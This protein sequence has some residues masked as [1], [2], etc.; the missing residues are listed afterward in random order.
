MWKYSD[1]GN[2][3]IS[4]HSTPF[5]AIDPD[6]TIEQEHKKMKAK[7]GFTGITGKEEAMDK[8]FV[9]APTLSRLVQELKDYGGIENKKPTSLHHELVGGKSEKY[10]KLSQNLYMY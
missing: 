5:T 7:G 1:E 8:H 4:K 2:F 3:V 10:P 6:H 9:I